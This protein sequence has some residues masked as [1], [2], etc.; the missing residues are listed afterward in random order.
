MCDDGGR[1]ERE[2]YRTRESTRE[3]DVG[4]SENGLKSGINGID[5]N[6]INIM[7]LSCNKRNEF[8]LLGKQ[9]FEYPLHIPCFPDTLL[10]MKEVASR[11][12]V[13]LGVI[14]SLDGDYCFLNLVQVL[15][16]L[17]LIP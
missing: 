15:I 12:Y 5:V 7:N 14:V 16:L 17:Y 2:R 4:E 1:G 9:L 11:R 3:Q 8:E 13:I 10:M 6:N